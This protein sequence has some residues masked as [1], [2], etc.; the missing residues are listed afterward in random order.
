MFYLS[1]WLCSLPMTNFPTSKI[2]D[3]GQAYI[4]P[5][6]PV[7]LLLLLL[8]IIEIVHKVQLKEKKE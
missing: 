6:V 2:L 3:L 5:V 4:Y 1:Q 7:R 8:I